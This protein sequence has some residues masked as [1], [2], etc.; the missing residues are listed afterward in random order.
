MTW[1][2]QRN[3]HRRHPCR[4]MGNGA[5]HQRMN[6][7]GQPLVARGVR[8]LRAGRATVAP[9]EM[10]SQLRG[11]NHPA[12]RLD[13]QSQVPRGTAG[14]L[15]E[16][17]AFI[18]GVVG[19]KMKQNHRRV[20]SSSAWNGGKDPSVVSG[21]RHCCWRLFF[22]LDGSS[23]RTTSNARVS[24]GSAGRRSHQR[25][26]WPVMPCRGRYCIVKATLLTLCTEGFFT[27]VIRISAVVV[28]G[29]VT[30][31]L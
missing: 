10:K 8:D 12:S 7:L 4:C 27:Q 26:A 13:E 31:Q 18:D 25:F 17:L 5:K 11:G 29:P 20:E 28:A 16:P 21:G 23:E 30:T 2:V 15:Y 6:G 22:E 24:R 9:M 19:S 3:R 14:G 1:A